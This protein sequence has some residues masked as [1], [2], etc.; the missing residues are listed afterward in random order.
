MSDEVNASPI[1][2]IGKTFGV[3][4]NRPFLLFWIG[5]FI[6]N[7]GNWTENAAQSWAVRDG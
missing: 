6:S 1:S 4:R 2:T 7:I 5:I 3:F